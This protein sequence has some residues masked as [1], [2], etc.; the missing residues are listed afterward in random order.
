MFFSFLFVDTVL[1]NNFNDNFFNLPEEE[2]VTEYQRVMDNTMGKGVYD[3][4]KIR[5]YFLETWGW[6]TSLIQRKT[7]NKL[8]YRIRFKKASQMGIYS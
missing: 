7:N 4:E 6:E 2:V 3:I 8:M 1:A 5:T